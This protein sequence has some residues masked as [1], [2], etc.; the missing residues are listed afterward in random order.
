[1]SHYKSN[2]RDIEFNLFELLGRS[3]L[4]D[5]GVWGHMDTDTV[6]SMLREVAVMA[7]GSLADS[8]ADADRNPPV[9]DPTSHPVALPEEFKKSFRTLWESGWFD[10]S[11]D[12]DLGGIHPVYEATI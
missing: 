9:F 8:F 5:A 10:L 11:L 6:R 7:E 3:P 1:M 4:L 12:P 2:L